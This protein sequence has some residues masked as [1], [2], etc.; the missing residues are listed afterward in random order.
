MQKKILVVEDNKVNR[1]L[2]CRMLEKEYEIIQAENGLEAYQIIQ[3]NYQELSAVILDLVMPVMDGKEL[4]IQMREE[5]LYANLPILIATGEHNEKSETECLALGAWDFI[6]K[7]YSAA[8]IKMRLQN[9]IARSQNELMAQ[10]QELAQKDVLTGLYNR[11]FFMK[12]TSILLKSNPKEQFVLVHMD[13]D[14]FRLYN[15]SFGSKAGNE[16]LKRIAKQLLPELQHHNTEYCT[17]GRIESDVFCICMPYRKD[18]LLEAIYAANEKLQSM[19]EHYRIKASFGLYVIKDINDDME[20][21]YTR[22]VEAASKCKHNVNEQYAFYSEEMSA[23]EEKEQKFTNEIDAALKERQFNVYLQPKYNVETGKPCGAEALVRWIHPEWGMVSPGDFIP[24][25]EHNGLI[26]QLDYYMW[27]RVCELLSKWI[28]TGETV[29][30]VSVNISRISMYNPNIVDDIYELTQ[31][32]QVPTNLLNLEITES[33]YMSNPHL[34]EDIIGKFRALGFVIL[35]DDF[36]S[37]YSSLNTLKNIEVDIL[38]IDMKFLPTGQNNVKSEKILASVARMAGWL[39]MP[40]IVEGVETKEQR[41]FL[42]SIGCKYIQGYF[43]ARPMPVKDYE[44]LIGEQKVHIEEKKEISEAVLK[45]FD[46]LWSSDTHTETLL[47]TVAVPFAI[48]EYGNAMIDVLRKNEQFNM[49]FGSTS[50][51]EMMSYKE[52]SKLTNKL[53]ELVDASEDGECDILITMPNGDTKWQHVRIIY[54]G[55]IERTSLLSI[56]LTDVTTERMMEVEVNHIF[57]ALKN[58]DMKRN[59]MLIVDDVEISREV[60]SSLFEDSYKILLA[61]D[62]EEALRLLRENSSD[63]VAIL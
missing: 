5:G 36:G 3:K 47:K 56:T 35:M 55:T 57:E 44:K 26:L 28:K 48:I 29:Y 60:L 22:A 43:Y 20:A 58:T 54:I 32:Y 51:E 15:A 49:E 17:Y 52:L 39:G 62:G 42:K 23:L 34:M 61:S 12:Q 4:L 7:P 16:L 63:I 59:T 2:M 8:I 37:G 18:Q 46:E 13:I 24:A 50:I 33:A 19:S 30:P 27:E 14:H 9:I 6:L 10:V 45:S 1:T 38:K 25:F 53:D 31:K 11:Q 21:M 41:D 40:V